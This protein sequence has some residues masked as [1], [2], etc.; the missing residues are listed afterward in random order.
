LAV[1]SDFLDAT[2]RNLTLVE[3]RVVHTDFSQPFTESARQALIQGAASARVDVEDRCVYVCANGPRYE[4]PFEVDLY[5]RA[6]GDVVGMTAASEA[7]ALRESGVAYACLAVVTNSA[8]G[9]EPTPLSHEDVVSVMR[10]SADRVLAI[11]QASVAI[12]GG[13][14]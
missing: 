6:G 11:L 10:S 12:L 9:I 14:G 3:D 5:R 13:Q 4:T 2:G 8:C 7:I 1:C